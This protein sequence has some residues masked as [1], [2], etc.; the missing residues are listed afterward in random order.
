VVI[1]ENRT[2]NDLFATFPGANGRTSG[3]ELLNGKKELLN[4]QLRLRLG[5]PDGRL[6]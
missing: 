6:Q 2:F 5:L 1:Q 3:Y 4:L